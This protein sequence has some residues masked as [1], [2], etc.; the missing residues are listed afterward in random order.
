MKKKEE[1][2]ENIKS[3]WEENRIDNMMSNKDNLEYNKNIK[4]DYVDR[5]KNL[6]ARGEEKILVEVAF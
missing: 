2:K 5:E 1:E 4:Q 3:I 6:K